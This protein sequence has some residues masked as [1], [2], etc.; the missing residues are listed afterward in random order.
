M[1]GRKGHSALPIALQLTLE[2]CLHQSHH[3]IWRS[4]L[5]HSEQSARLTSLWSY[6]YPL[7]NDGTHE[8]TK[9]PAFEYLISIR[10]KRHCE[11]SPSMHRVCVIPQPS[12]SRTQRRQAAMDLV[13]VAHS[14]ALFQNL[15]A[16]V[17]RYW[18]H[19][20]RQSPDELLS[21][22]NLISAHL[23]RQF[24]AELASYR[25]R[26]CHKWLGMWMLLRLPQDHQ[27]QYA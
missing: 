11:S 20:P 10:Y 9:I 21:P 12:Y 25:C 22:L 5:C 14:K 24:L 13:C 26:S 15:F 19:Y 27:L 4:G 1:I 2:S 8:S 16:M 6:L 18:A 7:E 3:S 17:D 23:R